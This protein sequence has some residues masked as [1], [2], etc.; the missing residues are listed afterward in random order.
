[1]KSN[2]NNNTNMKINNNTDHLHRGV[3]K[4]LFITG[5]QPVSKKE[6]QNLHQKNQQRKFLKINNPSHTMTRQ[7]FEQSKNI[8]V[9]IEDKSKEAKKKE[10]PPSTS[11]KDENTL[12]KK[13]RNFD[14]Y[15]EEKENN[16][17][18]AKKILKINKPSHTMTRQEYEQSKH[19]SITIE[20]KSKEEKKIEHPDCISRKDESTLEKKRR[21]FDE[22]MEEKENNKE[23]HLLSLE[24]HEKSKDFCEEGQSRTKDNSRKEKKK[25]RKKEK[26]ERKEKKEKQDEIEKE[27]KKEKLEEGHMAVTENN[28]QLTNQRGSENNDDDEKNPKKFNQPLNT[29]TKEEK[30]QRECFS[31]HGTS[32]IEWNS[33]IDHTNN[34]NTQEKSTNKR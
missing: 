3:L 6:L 26:K 34:T 14:E 30:E 5:I 27:K 12:Q 22:C 28:E 9:A 4:F 19:I 21:N 8:S 31:T 18:S 33:R 24:E 1:M 29:I 13:R 20:D 7:E 17:E 2:N 11:G 32:T 23:L 25:K 10:H 15:M 16:E